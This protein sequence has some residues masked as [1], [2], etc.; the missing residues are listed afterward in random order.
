MTPRHVLVAALA[1]LG[2]YLIALGHPAPAVPE[3]PGPQLL[4][5]DSDGE[6]AT[7]SDEE[8]GALMEQGGELYIKNCSAC[9]GS[10]G[11]GGVGPA[12]A[13]NE[14]LADTEHV[15]VTIHEGLGFMPPFASTLNDEQIAAVA[16][17]IRNSWGNEFGAITAEE[18][19]ALR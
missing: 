7:V 10:N 3:A 14:N 5:V 11:E 9:H 19:A 17:Y 18:S 15:L 6:P 16:T 4:K 2:I 12:H 13:G 1:C 8:F